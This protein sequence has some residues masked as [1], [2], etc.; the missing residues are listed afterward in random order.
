M[1][2]VKWNGRAELADAV[3]GKEY[4]V[5]EKGTDNILVRKD[6]LIKIGDDIPLS[7]AFE[8]A[9]DRLIKL[10]C[11]VAHPHIRIILDCTGL[12]VLEGQMSIQNSS[13]VKD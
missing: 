13:H 9:S 2:T 5:Y 3:F 10:L 6:E 1:N 7:K 4:W 11:E 8:D 12:E